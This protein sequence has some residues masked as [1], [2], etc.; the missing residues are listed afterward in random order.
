MLDDVLHEILLE[1]FQTRRGLFP[2]KIKTED[3]LK[4]SYQVFRTLR[5][6]SDTVALDAKVNPDDIDIV[7][8]WEGVECAKNSRPGRSMRHHYSDIILLLLPFFR[9]TSAH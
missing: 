2:G 7:N 6:T 4:T 8:R 3:E 5:R 1:L 9:Y